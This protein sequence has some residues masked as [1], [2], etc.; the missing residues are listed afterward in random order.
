M[1]DRPGLHYGRQLSAQC[2]ASATSRTASPL[3]R[4]RPPGHGA[5]CTTRLPAP[6][7]RP[8]ASH[9]RSWGAGPSALSSRSV[10]NRMLTRRSAPGPSAPYRRLFGLDSV[11]VA[12]GGDRRTEAAHTRFMASSYRRPNVC[13][14]LLKA[15]ELRF[16]KT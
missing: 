12:E 1:K 6:G 8:D 5:I 14:R 9:G 7:N 10:A 11:A 15:A 4:R 16:R 2:W 13:T 3:P